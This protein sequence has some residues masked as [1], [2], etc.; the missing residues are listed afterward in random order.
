MTKVTKQVYSN[1]T[2][3]DQKV[4]TILFSRIMQMLPETADEAVLEGLKKIGYPADRIPHFDEITTLI[5]VHTDTD[6]KIVPLE[7]MVDDK[8]FICMLAEKK[9]PCR[10]W[11]RSA[12]QME[13]DLDEYDMFHDVI[14]HTPLLTRHDYCYYLQGL[15]KLALKYINNDE[16]ISLLKRVYWHTIQFGLKASQ[17]ELKVYGAHLLTSRGETA[18]SISA[19]VP[20]Y[21]LNIEKIMDTPYRKGKYQERY[22]VINNYS[23]LHDSLPE[24]E[25]QLQA[26]IK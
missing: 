14:G 25:K 12:E 7:D 18:Y 22:F 20:K 3:E 5:D 26:R 9:Y 24:I 1:Y 4:W 19:G 15:G 2:E 16:A 21:D 17:Q 13:A 10:T 23:D 6:W 11:L 8:E